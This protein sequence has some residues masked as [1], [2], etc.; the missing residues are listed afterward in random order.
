MK[1]P[2]L[3]SSLVNSEKTKV[4]CLPLESPKQRSKHNQHPEKLSFE[5]KC[6]GCRICSSKIRRGPG[7]SSGKY[8]AAPEGREQPVCGSSHG[9]DR[10]SEE[11]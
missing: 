3:S 10:G 7:K 5:D 2:L 1:P 8:Q 9:Q 4:R 6:K 11:V